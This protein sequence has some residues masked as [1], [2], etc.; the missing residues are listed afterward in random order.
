MQPPPRRL[1]QALT[2]RRRV[3]LSATRAGC[4]GDDGHAAESD[5]TEWTEPRSDVA[6]AV[7]AADDA[8]AERGTRLE[9]GVPCENSVDAPAGTASGVDVPGMEADDDQRLR[10]RG[11]G[12]DGR[13]GTSQRP[14]TGPVDFR[15]SNHPMHISV[16]QNC[17]CPVHGAGRYV[18]CQQYRQ[19]SD[20]G[21]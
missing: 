8:D 21:S 20:M 10:G 18:K 2:S 1:R 14:A 15:F 6:D 7:D 9:Y 12:A 5:M 16:G 3:G 11:L 13:S 4:P 19:S 17:S